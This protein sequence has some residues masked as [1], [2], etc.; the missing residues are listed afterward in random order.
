MLGSWRIGRPLGIDLSIHSSFW[1]LPLFVLVM[2]WGR[3]A[4]AAAFDVAVVLAAFGCVALHELGHALA[5]RWYGI[6][7]RDIILYPIGGVA[8]LDRIPER[9][10]PE[11]VIALAGPAVNVAIAAALGLVLLADNFA[12]GITPSDGHLANVFLE[13]LLV[14]N[15]G[16]VLFNLIPAFPM[17]G[18][19]VLRATLSWFTNR[20]TATN[21]ASWIGAG[22]AVLFGVYAL[23]PPNPQPMLLI[24]AF[25]LFV[26]GR[27]EAMMVRMM[28]RDRH[29]RQLWDEAEDIP[30]F[31]P[32]GRA[33]R[34]ERVPTR[35]DGWV[36][37][38]GTREW[39]EYRDGFPVRRFR[40]V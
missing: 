6:R 5:A 35:T 18:G 2:G 23:M 39:T 22:F 3:G 9:P 24:L 17:D 30:T 34:A 12:L 37:D 20:V 14:V 19:R 1:L 7:T 32:Y 40:E 29:R 27:Q 25:A 13:R 33:V 4:F 31:G 38:V 26:M 11:I 10:W 8:R 16:L 21:V 15:V 28:E 36:F